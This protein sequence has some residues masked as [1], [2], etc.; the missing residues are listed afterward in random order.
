MKFSLKRLGP[1]LIFAGAAIGVSHLVQST[2]AGADFG[3]GLLWAL[4]LIHVIK[5]PFFLF[6]PKYTTATGQSLIDGYH[7]LGKPVLAIYVILTFLTMFTIQAAVTIVTAGLA[8]HLF[9]ITQNMVIWSIIITIIC[10]LWLWIGRYKMLD[11]LM[12]VIIIILAVT[13]IVA[14][15]IGAFK[16]THNFSISPVFPVEK[17]NIAFLIAFLGWMPAPL[18]ISI[19][20]SLWT[21]EKA[22]DATLNYNVKKSIFDFNVGYLTCILLGICFMAL[23]AFAMFYSNQNIESGA[24]QFSQQ[25]VELYTSNLGSA[26][27]L[28]VAIAA[29]TA[30]LSTTITTLDASPRAMFKSLDLLYSHRFNSYQLWIIVLGIGTISI[31]TFFIS[32]MATMVKVATILSFLTAPFYAIVNYLLMNHQDTPQA[33][34]PSKLMKIWSFLG[35]LF[36]LGFG[37][38]YLKSLYT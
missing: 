18:D 11:K 30:M 36:L 13:S 37:L 15:I 32:D 1:G 28:F 3:F 29:F 4:L 33:Y 34:R 20:Q 22:K 27:G 7:K 38:W 23:G 8:A 26:S 35:I 25:L 19:W 10:G 12:K 6:G 14:V 17:V 2:K 5:Y 9:G 16:S 21:V 31:L 24:V